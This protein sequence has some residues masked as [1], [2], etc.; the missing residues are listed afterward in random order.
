MKLSLRIIMVV[1]LVWISAGT[2][3]GFFF[4]DALSRTGDVVRVES[5]VIHSTENARYTSELT[6]LVLLGGGMITLAGF[7]RRMMMRA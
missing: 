6:S 7:S 4:S 1:A 2:V 5:G 3:Y